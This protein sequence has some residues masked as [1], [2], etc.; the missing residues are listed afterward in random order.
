MYIYLYTSVNTVQYIITEKSNE[1]K[2]Q[3]DF[4]DFNEESNLR[5]N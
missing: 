3:E 5:S 4:K 1:Y 2:F